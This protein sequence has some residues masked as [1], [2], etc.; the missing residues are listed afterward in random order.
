MLIFLSTNNR[1]SS[2]L[3]ASELFTRASAGRRIRSDATQDISFE[4]TYCDL[5]DKR[6]VKNIRET[7]DA[8]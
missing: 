8:P 2:R 4:N 1:N 7:L 5:Q 3:K 6:H